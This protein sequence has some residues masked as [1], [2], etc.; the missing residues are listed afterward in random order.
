MNGHNDDGSTELQLEE[1]VGSAH[2][3]HTE[4]MK[5]HDGQMDEE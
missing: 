4:D 1:A 3:G 2:N 5:G